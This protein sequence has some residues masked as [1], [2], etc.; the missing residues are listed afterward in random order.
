MRFRRAAA[1][2]VSFE[3]SKI[4]LHN[5]LTN[6]RIACS[7]QAID[8]L[9]KLDKWH[10]PRKLM[11]YFPDASPSSLAQQVARLVKH[12]MLVAERTSQAALDEKYRHDWQWGV[13]A[14][15]FHFS[16]RD[17]RF[18]TGK[19]AETYMRKRK[20]WRP[21]PKLH[22]PNSTRRA[23]RLPQT[24]IGAEP[25]ALMSRRRSQRQFDGKPLPLA[26]LSDCLF[27]GNGIVEFRQDET[28][29]SLP[30][31]MTPSGG[32]R[33]PFELYIYAQN[34]EG[35]KPGF[36]HYGALKH[37]LGLVRVG[38]VDVPAMLGTQRWPARAGAIVFLVAHF[39]RSMWK[40]HMPMAYRVVMMEAGFIGQNIALMATHHGLSAVPSGALN[41]SL[42]E[43]YLGTPA[44]ES[45]VVLS[46]N[47]G[48]P[49]KQRGGSRSGAQ[50]NR[51]GHRSF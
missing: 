33:N 34:I 1:L 20:A 21:S 24:D 25:L 7:D 26:A 36:Y 27:A 6:D 14:G 47:I 38:K 37:D 4:V 10:T 5:F 18:V 11:R 40:Y 43:G 32:A 51:V 8:F 30:I 41:T 45:G 31:A 48:R 35:L 28:Y 19:T 13:P 44:V 9:S 12:N 17:T 50:R 15:L 39:P 3:N 16:I 22:E 29:G 2:A 42:V 49:K 46:L 23:T